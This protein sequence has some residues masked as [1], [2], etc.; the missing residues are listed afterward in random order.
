MFLRGLYLSVSASQCLC[1]SVSQ[2]FCIS[3]SLY[4]TVDVSQCLCISLSLYLRVSVSHCR[5]IS[6]SLYL[7]VAIS[8]CRFIS[9]SL[10]LNVAVSQFLFILLSLYLIVSVSH[11]LCI[12]MSL[13]LR[14]SP[15]LY[16]FCY[17]VSLYL[18]I[19][20][21]RYCFLFI[22]GPVFVHW[23]GKCPRYQGGG[24]HI[25]A[26][27]ALL[28]S[29]THYCC[30]F[31]PFNHHLQSAYT[32]CIINLRKSRDKGPLLHTSAAHIDSQHVLSSDTCFR[33]IDNS[34]T[35]S[36]GG[37][38]GGH[39]SVVWS[40]FGYNSSQGTQEPSNLGKNWSMDFLLCIYCIFIL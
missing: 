7:T 20:P 15:R 33:K 13:Y 11:S 14:C 31:S 35:L 19:S 23:S 5:C 36:E 21:P 18:R 32:Y 39:L 10:Y 26:N 8:Q 9:V 30:L 40:V 37:E 17:F 38:V 22:L 4:R 12:S 24:G 29:Y 6:L 16:S 25:G 34:N 27:T 28:F 3:V 2:F 1:I